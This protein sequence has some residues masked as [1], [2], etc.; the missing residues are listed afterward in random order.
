[1]VGQ[2]GGE[3]PVRWHQLK[4]RNGVI[5]LQVLTFIPFHSSP[6]LTWRDVQHIVVWTS[7]W[8]ALSHDPDWNVNG[9]GR[10]VNLKFGFGLLDAHAIVALAKLKKKVPEKSIC[11]GQINQDRK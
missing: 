2:G 9:L 1:V 7:K 6:N 3:N 4:T 10:H 11:H 8:R 5:I